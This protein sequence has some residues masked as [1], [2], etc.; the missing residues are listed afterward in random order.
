MTNRLFILLTILTFSS[1]STNKYIFSDDRFQNVGQLT[2]AKAISRDIA[3]KYKDVSPDHL[4]SIGQGI[5][6]NSKKFDLATPRTFEKREGAFRLSTD[7]YYSTPDSLVKVILYQWEKARTRDQK[8]EFQKLFDK[9]KQSLTDKLGEPQH[10]EINQKK[11]NEET[12]R[13][14]VKWTGKVNAY[15]FYL[16]RDKTE[17]RRI[18]LAIYGE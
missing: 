15:L 16:R 12:F 4:I 11:F 18:R 8:K 5:Y 7:Y 3:H 9:L 1:C 6:P 17:F 14:G 2:V 10:V 13:D